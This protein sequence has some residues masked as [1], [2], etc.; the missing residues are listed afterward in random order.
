MQLFAICWLHEHIWLVENISVCILCIP[1]SLAFGG[2]LGRGNS[3][4]CQLIASNCVFNCLRCCTPPSPSALH[5][6]CTFACL[7]LGRRLVRGAS[8]TRAACWLVALGCGPG[9]HLY[10]CLNWGAADT[11]YHAHTT[12][13]ECYRPVL[14]HGDSTSTQPFSC[15]APHHRWHRWLQL[16]QQQQHLDGGLTCILLIG[17]YCTCSAAW[18]VGQVQLCSVVAD[19]R[20][21]CE[22]ATGPG[23]ICMLAAQRGRCRLS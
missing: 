1:L 12:A 15:D 9:V 5:V 23:R 19:H 22:I 11:T 18:G 13:P 21:I 20:L 4:G 3:S 17:P 2:C 7:D 8:H 10:V 14:A 6:H 16:Q